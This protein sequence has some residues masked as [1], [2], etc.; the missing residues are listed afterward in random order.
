VVAERLQPTLL[1][2]R[3]PNYTGEAQRRKGEHT[4]TIVIREAKLSDAPHTLALTR[5]ALGEPDNWL[6]STP[7]EFDFSTEDERQFILELLSAP[8]S[9]YFVAECR[10]EGCDPLIVGTV[11]CRGYPRQATQHVTKLG[12]TIAQAWRDQGIGGQLIARA[13]A[14]ARCTGLVRRIELNVMQP[15]ARAIHVYQKYGFVVE[16]VQRCA[17]I[18]HGQYVDNLMMALLIE[19]SSTP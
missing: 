10:E 12:I 13:V 11:S 7:R 17:Y 15:N 8:N 4:M 5:K 19:D 16:G 6:I 1:Q 14:W 2:S 3:H 18:K 9:C